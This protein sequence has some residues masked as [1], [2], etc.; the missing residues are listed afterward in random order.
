MYY[1]A[2]ILDKE[3]MKFWYN[4]RIIHPL[5]EAFVYIPLEEIAGGPGH[6]P[7]PSKMTLVVNTN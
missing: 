4:Q 7:S 5:I 1:I 6:G 2:I 3:F